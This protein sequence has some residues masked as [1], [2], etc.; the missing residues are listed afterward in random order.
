MDGIRGK[1]DL[2]HTEVILPVP[3]TMDDVKFFPILT[4]V[5]IV[6]DDEIIIGLGG[7]PLPTKLIA[8][9]YFPGG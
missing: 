4:L 5:R 7:V 9:G 3:H 6:G 1:I 8:E 2:S